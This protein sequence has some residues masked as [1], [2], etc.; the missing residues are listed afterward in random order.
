[1]TEEDTVPTEEEV[2][3]FILKEDLKTIQVLYWAGKND[4]AETLLTEKLKYHFKIDILDLR[5]RVAVY[6]KDNATELAAQVPYIVPNGDWSKCMND[7][8]TKQKFLEEE[9]AKS[10]LW[11]VKSL[12]NTHLPKVWAVTFS[13]DKV[14]SADDGIIGYAYVSE[15]GVV[16]HIFAQGE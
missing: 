1:M 6:V 12:A 9:G 3:R 13:M 5:D 10:E 15:T 8:E 16:K 14:E 2:K 4:E 11:R 7:D